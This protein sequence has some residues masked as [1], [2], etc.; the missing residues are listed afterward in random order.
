MKNKLENR[1]L[2]ICGISL[3]IFAVLQGRLMVLATNTEYQNE[4][5]RQ[6][7][8]TLNIGNTRGNIFDSR[9]DSLTNT[10]KILYA[11]V[12]PGQK[13]Y[14]ELFE[15]VNQN[16]RGELYASSN[17]LKPFLV[18]I[19]QNAASSEKYVFESTTR[20][21]TIPIAPQLI[22]Y[23]DSNNI[24]CAGVES[25]YDDI[26]QNAALKRTVKVT[27]NAR[28]EVIDSITPEVITQ[29]NSG[30]GVMLCIDSRI[31]RICE[32]IALQMIDKGSIVVMETK[33]GR[34]RASVSMPYYNPNNIS[35]SLS[36]NDAPFINRAI[37]Q[38][39]VGSVYKPLLA[40]T[41]IEKNILV[42]DTY[43][44][45]GFIEIDGHTY[46]CAYGKGHGE[47]DLKKALEVSCN[48]YFVKLGQNLG[49]NTIIEA[50][51]LAGFGEST[52]FAG[53]VLT[54][55]GNMPTADVLK[56]TGELANISFGQGQLMATPT[57]I[58]AFI[59][60][61]ANNGVYVAPTFVEAIVNQHT[62]EIVQSLYSPPQRVTFSPQTAL[63][64]K[65]MLNSVVDNG[66]A[67]K[68]KPTHTTAAGKTGTAQTGRF[69]S[70]NQEYMDAW[71]AG[72]FPAESPKYTVV[73][74]L[75]EGMH[76]SDD[77]CEIFSQIADTI[78]LLFNDIDK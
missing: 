10:N 70:D 47:V 9:F 42:T 6:S 43:F 39:S 4:A 17:L 48:C 68:A 11:L 63:Q 12:S 52:I 1:M 45:E 7:E 44:C 49:A 60:I 14:L 13:N 78:Y 34:V 58:A 29:Q 22:G 30:N 33:S 66:L 28:G 31:Q 26:L 77:A 53:N 16:Q 75:D 57:Q 20:Y 71:F 72:F 5:I 65:T 74:L 35:D 55:K 67:L 62:R 23:V 25:A 21:P 59:N 3:V 32:D 56:N 61:F 37:S 19:S 73:V 27:T 50:S 46:K 51:K 76:N 38:F 40:A 18:P 41:A 64:I 8:F 24:G 2:C 36:N 69:N 15:K 54:A